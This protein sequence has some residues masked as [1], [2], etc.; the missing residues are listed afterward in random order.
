MSE[1]S[2]S[3]PKHLDPIAVVRARTPARL[4]A[5]RAGASYRTAT[6]LELRSDRAAALDAVVAENDLD[7]DLGVDLVRRFRLFEVSTRART[8]AEYLLR[9]DL[10]RRLDDDA[11]ATIRTECPSAS[12]MQI[13]I[14]DGLSAA[15]VAAQVPELLPL[16]D[17]EAR[18]RGWSM[19]RPFFV[20]HCRVGIL[21]DIGELLNPE[22]VVLL[23]GERPG[24]ATAKSLS[25]YMAHR[26]RPGHTDAQRNLISN[27]HARGI[28]LEEAARRILALAERMRQSQTSGVSIKEEFA[29]S[30][31]GGHLT[32]GDSRPRLA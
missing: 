17:D 10:G 31:G 22:V 8:K 27:I 4:F 30:T 6:Q 1:A 23:I 21:N 28:G 13:V 25:A 18:R 7:R 12:T 24:L 14:G 3:L 9:P 11:R 32:G 19:G 20:R 26:P 16:L 5:G 29:E 2:E 15:A